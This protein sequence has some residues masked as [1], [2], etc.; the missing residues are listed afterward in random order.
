MGALVVLPIAGLLVAQLTGAFDLTVPAILWIALGL[1][2]LNVAL[3]R[4]AVVLFDRE[5]ILT[6]WR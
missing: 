6:R 4:V 3:L 2:V 5:S 1:A